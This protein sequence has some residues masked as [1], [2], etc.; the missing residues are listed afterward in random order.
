LRE[1]SGSSAELP[2]RNE[3]QSE[4]FAY[5]YYPPRF[6]FKLSVKAIDLAAIL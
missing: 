6:Q 2:D 5:L 4:F 1:L 3:L